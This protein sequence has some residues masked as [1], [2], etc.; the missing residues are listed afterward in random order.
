MDISTY[1][2]LKNH[3]KRSPILSRGDS[4]ISSTY[5]KYGILCAA[6]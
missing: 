5:R 3:K 1:G 6:Q 2:R 4:I